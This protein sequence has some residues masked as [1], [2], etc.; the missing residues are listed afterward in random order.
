METPLPDAL[1]FFKPQGSGSLHHSRIIQRIC[2]HFE[3]YD[4]E[5]DI[6]PELE[7]KLNQKPV[8]PDISVFHNLPEDWNTDVIFF[9]EA[10]VIAI[11]VLSP[12][13]ALSEI[14]DKVNDIYF[15]AGVQSVWI[16]VPLLQTVIIKTALAKLTF[17]EGLITDPVIRFEIPFNKI[18]RKVS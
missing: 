6:F 14:T 2:S 16:V 17:T 7:L 8:K 13:Q 10:P 4:A 18:F 12:K 5:Y 15:P 11:E 1:G 3:Q 9:T